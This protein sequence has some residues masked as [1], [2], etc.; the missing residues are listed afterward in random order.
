M[1]KNARTKN[2]EFL[3]DGY[4]LRVDDRK[5][6]QSMFIGGDDWKRLDGFIKAFKNKKMTDKEMRYHIEKESRR[7]G[8]SGKSSFIKTY[9]QERV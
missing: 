8:Y 9:L 2:F 4:G 3:W 7:M 6:K 1:I 5:T